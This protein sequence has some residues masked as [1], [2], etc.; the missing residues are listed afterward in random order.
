MKI[1]LGHRG[2]EP[3]A[4]ITQDG[5]PVANA[6][7]FCSSGEVATV[8]ESPNGKESGLYLPNDS[9]RRVR[10]RIVLPEMEKEWTRDIEIPVK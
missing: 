4:A 6:M 2:Q 1:S 5:Q 8:Y 10:F 9:Q 3:V 7:V